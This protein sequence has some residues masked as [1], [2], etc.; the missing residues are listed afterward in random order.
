MKIG[1][2]IFKMISDWLV[3][4]CCY[5]I[6]LKTSII[7]TNTKQNL[8]QSEQNDYFHCRFQSTKSSCE[9]VLSI[10]RTKSPSPL[11]S[12]RQH[13][14]TFILDSVLITSQDLRL[15]APTWRDTTISLFDEEFHGP[16]IWS[17]HVCLLYCSQH[18]EISPCAIYKIYWEHSYWGKHFTGRCSSLNQT[19]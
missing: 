19:C 18:E 12:W 11:T 5:C 1:N 9:S 13:G 4:C 17:A 16:I 10:I 3:C 6:V 15:N 14:S 8:V 2:A 7:V